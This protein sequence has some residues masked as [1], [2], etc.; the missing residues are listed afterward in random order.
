ME[1]NLSRKNLMKDHLSN[2]L[3]DL[4]ADHALA[5]I[6]ASDVIQAANVARQTFY[7]HFSDI[8]DLVCYTATRALYSAKQPI[9][10]KENLRATY[11]YA[12]EHKAFFS[13][14][15]YHNGQNSFKTVTARWLKERSYELFAGPDLPEIEREYRRL[16]MDIYFVGEGEAV[17]DWFA[18]GM[19]TPPLE[20]FLD[21]VWDSAPAFMKLASEAT[22][23]SYADYPR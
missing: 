14:L 15:K 22:P 20:T 8:D 21:A 10:S 13:Q 2:T 1:V 7:N 12:S 18:G 19:T 16:R 11:V 4:C 17:L 3:M 23:S 5:D 6:S 9:Y